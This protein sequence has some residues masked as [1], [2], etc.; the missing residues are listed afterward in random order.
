MVTPQYPGSP[1][2]SVAW[3][4]QGDSSDLFHFSVVI[5]AD[6]ETETYQKDVPSG[7]CRRKRDA[8]LIIETLTSLCSGKRDADVEGLLPKKKHKVTV[9]AVYRDS[10]EKEGSTEY[11]HTGRYRE[12]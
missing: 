7:T 3:C 6:G 11:S 1:S 4:F 5:Q 10:I 9:I 2:G 8:I 12:M